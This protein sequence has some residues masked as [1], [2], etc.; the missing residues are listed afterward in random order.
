MRCIQ[1]L[2]FLLFLGLSVSLVAASALANPSFEIAGSGIVVFNGWEQFG[3]VGSSTTAVHGSKAASLTG[4]TSGSGFRQQLQC[5]A[6]ERLRIAGY[7][8]SSASSPLSGGSTALLKVEWWNSS[9][10]QISYESFVLADAE[11]P[12]GQYQSFEELSS[13]APTGTAA[14]RIVLVSLQG[15]GDPAPLVLFDQITCYS[16]TYPTIDDVQWTDFPGGRS[17]EFS[18]RQWRVKGP[19]Y[20]GPGPNNFSDSEQSVWVD[21]QNRLHMT[22]RQIGGTWNSTEVVL[23]DTLGYGDYIFTTQG[24]LDQLDPRTVLGLFLWQYNSSVGAGDSY[25]NPYNE[26]DIEYSR[27]GNPGNIIGQFVAQ[28]YDW[29]GNIFRY[30]ASFGANEI[31]SHAFRWLPDR[32]ECRAWRGGPAAESPSTSIISW[33]YT[34]PHIPRPEQPRVHINLWYAGSPPSATQEVILTRFSYVP[35][36]GVVD[37]DDSFI[38]PVTASIINNYPNPFNPSTRISFS[39]PKAGSVKVDVYDLKG[40]KVASLMDEFLQVG[41]HQLEWNA[42]NLPS[43]VYFLKLQT[44]EGSTS[45]KC[46]LLK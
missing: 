29:Q 34:G 43:G 35:P 21:D 6:N 41:Q 16:T 30:D 32:V 40:R 5:A 36:G 2:L 4:Q 11:T 25:W 9:N 45:R 42:G 38:E 17:L 44:S 22:I 1:I 39:N 31:S 19:G 7:L 3:N 14:I 37:S 12:V 18:N 8:M 46:V 23:A 10:S 24:A 33:T 13:P 15:S 20:Y 28:P 26:F 27:W